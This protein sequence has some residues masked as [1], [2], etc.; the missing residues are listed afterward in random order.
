MIEKLSDARD[1]IA[2][3]NRYADSNDLAVFWRGQADY[4]WGLHSSLSR[5]LA[6]VTVLNDDL[7][8]RVEDVVLN[9]AEEWVADLSSN[10]YKRPLSR[11]AYLQHH[12][13]PTRLIDFTRDP[14]IALFFAAETHDDV[15]G[16]IFS[17][18]VEKGEVLSRTPT[19]TPWR[20]YRSSEVRVWDPTASGVVFPRLEAQDG[21]FAVGRLP[22]TQPHRTAW[23]AL[24]ERNRSLLA[25][26]VRR[27]FSVPFKL[28]SSEPI[29]QGATLPIGLTFRLHVNKESIR[30]SLKERRS[31]LRNRTISHKLVYPDIDGMRGYSAFL[32]G[33]AKGT[34]VLP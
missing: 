10:P 16:R 6:A 22:S 12:G 32:K 21:V 18:L 4:R 26:E 34:V 3:I 23:D 13:I 29:P 31:G 7:L 24:L 17:L 14:S 30:R 1:L 2:E 28:C 8:N 20:D 5:S 19:G 11:L 27:I 33:L 9:E 25:E 15:D